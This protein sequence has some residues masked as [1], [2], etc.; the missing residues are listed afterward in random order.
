MHYT[1][2][3]VFQFTNTILTAGASEVALELCF[4]WSLWSPQLKT[5]RQQ[6][7]IPDTKIE[8]I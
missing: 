6:Q 5:S 2:S 3:E 8:T 4:D 7:N 1:E